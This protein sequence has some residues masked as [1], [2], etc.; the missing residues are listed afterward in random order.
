MTR[1]LHPAEI[2]R[3]LEE[4]VRQGIAHR[5]RV[6]QSLVF[7]VT[8]LVVFFGVS[9][10]SQ[11]LTPGLS[12]SAT[13]DGSA[14]Q[15]GLRQASPSNALE[16]NPQD[17]TG[18]VEAPGGLRASV[19]FDVLQER[20]EAIVEVKSLMADRLQQQG[21]EIQANDISDEML[22][23]QISTNADLRAHIT[24]FLRARG[25]VSRDDLQAMEPAAEASNPWI[26]MGVVPPPRSRSDGERNDRSMD[27]S[28]ALPLS[29]RSSGYAG[30]TGPPPLGEPRSIDKQRP[31]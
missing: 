4:F 22:Y 24:T 14:S 17:A 15:D 29:A 6:A 5:F 20:P 10:R 26:D 21:S 3:T 25:Y 27:G 9:A 19:L 18:T 30:V 23:E 28:N 7:S 12:E 2:R 13:P 31:A 11:V 8:A 16:R 1:R